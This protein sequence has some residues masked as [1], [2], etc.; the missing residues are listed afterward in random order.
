MATL[1]SRPAQ[2]PAATPPHA[3]AHPAPPKAGG[4]GLVL[5]YVAAFFALYVALLTPVI[6]TLALRVSALSTPETRA[7]DLALVT[8]VGAFFAFVANPLA[9][10]LSDRTTSRLG[11]RRPWL[12]WGVL[13]GSAGIAIIALAPNIAVVA[14]GWAVAQTAFNGTQA[15]LQALLPDQVEE[16]LRARVSGW[17]GIAQNLAPL[18]GIGIAAWLT[19]AGA[20]SA[21]LFLL[22]TALA[23]VGVLALVAVLK[24]RRLDPADVE[25]FHLG[26]F[27]GGFWVSP[28]KHPDFGWAFAGRFLLLFGFALYNSYQV[29][30][31]QDRF[32]MDEPTALGWQLRLMVLQAAVLLLAGS[33][34]GALSDRTGRRKVFVIISTVLAGAGLLV[35]AFAG[36]PA[37]LYLGAALFG[38]GLG[39]YFAVD[40]ALVTDVLPNKDTEAAKN[41]GVF[42]IANALPQSLAPA[43]AP[44]LLAIGPASADGAG[45]NYTALF[46]VGALVAVVGA[47]STMFIRGA[48]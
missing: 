42:N 36:A 30:F 1:D 18:A 31:L 10:A 17:L 3:A 23:I 38:A 2:D 29:Y 26:R 48:R 11:M 9:G 19:A 39:A 37:H 20:G 22:P 27:L 24:D 45:G 5:A 35:F 47:V 40:L 25:P 32:G 4:T 8:G 21:W 16:R 34:G 44:A 6:S 41:M 7:A 46:L 43:M 13:L 14:I 28:R 12:L 15:A 33:A